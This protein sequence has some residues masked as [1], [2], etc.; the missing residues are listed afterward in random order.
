MRDDDGN[1][2]SITCECFENIRV[3]SNIRRSGLEKMID[4]YKMDTFVCKIDWQKK[5]KENADRYIV[6]RSHDWFFIG[7]QVGSGKTHIC[8]AICHELMKLGCELKYLSWRDYLNDLKS[9]FNRVDANISD[10][11]KEYKEIEVLFID[12]LFKS[13]YEK[14]P[15]TWELEML[16]ELIDFRYK[17]GLITIISSEL[18][19][20]DIVDIDESIGS[21]IF[22]KTSEFA[23]DIHKDKN[24]NVRF[25]KGLSQL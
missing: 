11:Q 18:S 15:T 12:D 21:R 22:E 9:S 24:K 5:I 1:T 23:I 6:K 7:G 17:N 4:K 14:K 10:K 3:L 16:S 25:M 8:V 2:N 19:V 13:G 20:P